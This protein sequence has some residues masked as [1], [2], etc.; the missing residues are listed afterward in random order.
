MAERTEDIKASTLF[1]RE[2]KALASSRSVDRRLLL[3]VLVPSQKFSVHI[4]NFFLKC[5]Y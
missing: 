3:A 5:V 4:M 1:K 2:I